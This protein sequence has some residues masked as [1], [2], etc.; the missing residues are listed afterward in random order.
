MKIDEQMERALRR[1]GDA[2]LQA[3]LER[4]KTERDFDHDHRMDEILALREISPK[5]RKLMDR[6][7]M[8]CEINRQVT[9]IDSSLEAFEMLE[10]WGVSSLADE[11][12]FTLTL[13]I[14]KVND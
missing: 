3:E 10:D 1:F 7:N 6:D 8:V 13:E 12:K 14:T 5:L 4:R 2:E 11:F 9:N